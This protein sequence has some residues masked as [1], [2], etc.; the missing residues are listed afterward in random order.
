MRSRTDQEYL[1]LE[2]DDINSSFT[3]LNSLSSAIL[4][5]TF[6]TQNLTEE[7][8]GSNL[9]KVMTRIQDFDSSIQ[10]KIIVEFGKLL[11]DSENENMSIYQIY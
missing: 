9:K 7:K 2:E 4:P 3:A 10:D 5:S 11:L 6:S 1:S 8:L